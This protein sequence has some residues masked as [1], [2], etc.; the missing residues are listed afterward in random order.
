VNNMSLPKLIIFAS[1]TKDG[2][3]SGFENLVASTLGDTPVLSAEIV[4]VVSNHAHGGVAKRAERLGVPFFHMSAPYTAEAYAEIVQK[5]G[6][7]WVALSGWLKKTTGL[8]PRCTFNI[9]P[10]PLFDVDG[11]FGGPGMYGHFVHEAVHAAYLQGLLKSSAVSM[12]FVTEGYDEGPVFFEYR[13]PITVGMTPEDIQK[14]V[15]EQELYWQ[16]RITQYVINGEIAWDGT[17]I[18]SMQLPEGYT[19]LPK[20]S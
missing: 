6:A 18:A 9:H 5:A 19:F 20:L 16:P 1:G 3:G 13:V 15:H 11:R 17:H 8:N 7:E 2:G 10:G 12:H 4:G 14:A